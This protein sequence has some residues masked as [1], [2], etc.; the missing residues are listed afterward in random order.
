MNRWRTGI[1][2]AGMIAQGFDKPGDKRVLSMAHA[3]IQVPNFKLGGFYDQDPCRAEEAEQKWDCPTTPRS[4]DKWLNS[5]WDVIYIATP[6]ECHGN[7]FRDALAHH[8][9]AILIEKPLATNSAEGVT[10]LEE[11][12][13]L[14]VI[15]IVDYPRRWHSATSKVAE[16]IRA[17]KVGIPVSAVF[18]VSGGVIHNL[19]HA[20]DLFL[21]WWGDGWQVSLNSRHGSVTCLT[22]S[23]GEVSFE[24][25]VIDQTA[26]LYYV[27]EM[28]IYCS[29]GKVELSYSPEIVELFYLKPHPAYPAY[30]VLTPFF[31]M[32]MEEEPLLCH[33]LEALAAAMAN[34]V[35]AEDPYR[36]E[37]ESQMFMAE[38]FHYFKKNN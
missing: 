9:R 7:D 26:Q 6:D 30:R 1:M 10:L 5:G 37:I 28:H 33:T 16:F 38:V 8:P 20:L 21:A 36:R 15:V 11:A 24:A 14:G 17:G 2:G 18:T 23:R 22:F 35:Q 34:P 31:R 19:S 12:Y 27:F 25:I 3:F 13:R 4:R 32:G 29:Q